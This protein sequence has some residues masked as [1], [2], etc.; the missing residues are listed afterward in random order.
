IKIAYIRTEIFV[1]GE[2]EQ[3]Q[4]EPNTTIEQAEDDLNMMKA[5]IQKKNRNSF[6]Y[7]LVGD[8]GSGKAFQKKELKRKIKNARKTGMGEISGD[9]YKEYMTYRKNTLDGEEVWMQSEESAAVVIKDF[10]RKIRD[11]QI[12]PRIAMIRS[13]GDEVTESEIT[14]EVISPEYIIFTNDGF[15]RYQAEV[16]ASITLTITEKE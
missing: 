9:D 1:N 8:D 11:E 2:L 15:K 10:V 16:E 3:M 6:F 14:S 5:F 13:N 12:R 7:H 4:E